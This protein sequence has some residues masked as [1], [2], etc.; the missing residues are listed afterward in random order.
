MAFSCINHD[1]TA[2]RNQGMIIRESIR[3]RFTKSAGAAVRGLH[4][5]AAKVMLGNTG[6]RTHPG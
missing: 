2:Q 6:N 1:F 5:Y 4:G 3:P